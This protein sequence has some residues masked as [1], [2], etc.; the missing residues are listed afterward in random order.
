M[1]YETVVNIMLKK[2]GVEKSTMMNSPCLRYRGNFVSK[3][4][5]QQ[6]ALIIKVSPERVHELIESGEG[7]P[8]NFT[9]KKF[10]EWVLIPADREKFYERYVEEALDYAKQKR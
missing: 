3:M 9:G 8:F 5:E 2:E 4:F 6:N 1:S 7:L 10:K